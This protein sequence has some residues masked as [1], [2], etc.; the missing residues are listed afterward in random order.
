MLQ[1]GKL[2]SLKDV[3]IYQAGMVVLCVYPV[4]TEPQDI[5]ASA[6]QLWLLYFNLFLTNLP[7]LWKCN[8]NFP[9]KVKGN[10]FCIEHLME[11][12]RVKRET[13]IT[14]L[15][16]LCVHSHRKVIVMY[17]FFISQFIF[18]INPLSQSIIYWLCVHGHQLVDCE[19]VTLFNVLVKWSYMDRNCLWR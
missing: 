14:N 4:R 10:M 7:N 16:Q 19:I 15:T 18:H 11:L 5:K 6:A 1:N 12:F 3:G 9:L 17:F 13:S 2:W 8:T